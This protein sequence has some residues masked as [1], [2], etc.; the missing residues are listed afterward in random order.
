MNCATYCNRL[1]ESLMYDNLSITSHK[2]N[3]MTAKSDCNNG[4]NWILW[5]NLPHRMC[6][7]MSAY[8]TYRHTHCSMVSTAFICNGNNEK[9]V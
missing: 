7:D 8:D 3:E 4:Y 5:G 6:N 2:Q 1:D 9:Y